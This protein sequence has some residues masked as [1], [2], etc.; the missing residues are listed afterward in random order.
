MNV[1]NRIILFINLNLC[2][3]FLFWIGL[4]I[5]FFRILSI[6]EFWDLVGTMNPGLRLGM[7]VCLVCA[8]AIVSIV[9]VDET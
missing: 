1:L 7:F 8:S 3:L 9:F 6:S 5:Y 4:N 2:H